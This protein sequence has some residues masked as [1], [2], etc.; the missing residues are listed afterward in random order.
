MSDDNWIDVTG[1]NPMGVKMTVTMKPQT[2]VWRMNSRSRK[3]S[4]Q[5]GR[6]RRLQNKRRSRQGGRSGG[7][8]P[9]DCHNSHRKRLRKADI[10]ARCG[11]LTLISRTIDNPRFLQ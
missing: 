5:I 6:M 9:C 11:A 8:L 7:F 1:G 3:T 2:L 4:K 10:G